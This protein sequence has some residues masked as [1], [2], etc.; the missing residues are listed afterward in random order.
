M[1]N[2]KISSVFLLGL[3]FLLCQYNLVH[4]SAHGMSAVETNLL[5]LL[6][7]TVSIF[8]LLKQGKKK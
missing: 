1:K 8:T 7:V 5:I 2:A 3:A 4:A 6:A